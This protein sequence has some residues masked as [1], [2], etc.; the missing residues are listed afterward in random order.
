MRLWINK[1]WVYCIARN[2]GFN[3]E[4]MYPSR[5]PPFFLNP[6]CKLNVEKTEG[7]SNIY[8]LNN[9]VS[10]S[11][12]VTLSILQVRGTKTAIFR[13]YW[14]ASAND[15]TMK[16]FNLNLYQRHIWKSKKDDFILFCNWVLILVTTSI[17][18]TIY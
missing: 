15:D 18:K 3:L 16:Y 6:K 14:S 17:L 8:G 12:L 11:K 9:H 10:E 5:P 7:S 2:M 13:L 1:I 4:N